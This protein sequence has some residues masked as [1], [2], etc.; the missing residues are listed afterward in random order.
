MKICFDK[1]KC[2]ACGACAVACM[3]LHD[4]DLAAGEEPFRKV[5]AEES[6]REG[7]LTISYFS[8]AC[9]HCE[10]ALCMESCPSG[11]MGRDEATG[12]V[13]AD[14]S[15]CVGCGACI[16]A[17]PFGA[18]GRDKTGK[19]AKCDGCRDFVLLGHAPVCVTACPYGA[20]TLET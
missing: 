3:S 15:R 14:Q 10:R 11:A 7:I 6:V 4:T 8:E 13:F 19:A 16:E 2:C 1:E 18:I 12:F 20:L 9:R 17:C 5:R